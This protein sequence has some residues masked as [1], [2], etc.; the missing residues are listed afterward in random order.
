MRQFLVLSLM[1]VVFSLALV[2]GEKTSDQNGLT[3]AG[4]TQGNVGCMILEKHMPVKG[5]LLF[6]GV[7]YARTEYHVLQTFNYKPARQKYTG[8]GQI[9]ELNRTA[10]KDKIKLVVLP[11]KYT[12]EQMNKARTLC[13]K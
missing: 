7:V 3:V 9:N 11:S 13:R 12:E 1:I 4:T 2:A 6:A 5:K 8:Q 10:I